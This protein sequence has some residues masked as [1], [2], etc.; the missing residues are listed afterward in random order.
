MCLL[1]FGSNQQHLQYTCWSFSGGNRTAGLLKTK[2]D[3][4]NL[5]AGAVHVIKC[6]QLHYYLEGG[7]RDSKDVFVR[8][9]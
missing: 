1:D 5:E 2:H 3:P 7:S 9:N 4:C 8:R 6:M